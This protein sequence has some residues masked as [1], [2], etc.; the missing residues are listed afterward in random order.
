MTYLMLTVLGPFQA[1]LVGEPIAGFESNKVRALLAYLAVEAD[2]PHP[3]D[4]LAGL[5]WPE[6]PDNAARNNLRYAL[7][8]LRKAIGADRATSPL[9]C[10]S[11]QAIQ[12]NIAGDVWVDATAFTQLLA[13]PAPDLADWE[14]AIA[15]YRGE[16]LEGFFLGD[17]PA[18]EEWLLLKREQFQ[19]RMLLALHRAS[20]AHAERGDY[21]RAL[22][23]TWR[24]VELEPW[25]E[26]AHRQLM[27]LLALNNQRSAALA[28]YEACR[29]AL[30]EEL[31]VEP[32]A[33]TAQLYEQI[34]DGKLVAERP[35]ESL[36]ARQ[37][38][39]SASAAPLPLE[40]RPP[41]ASSGPT[42]AALSARRP[43][44]VGGAALLLILAAV[45]IV[46]TSGG[47]LFGQN[48]PGDARL[49][50]AERVVT[51]CEGIKPPQICAG[52]PQTGRFTPLTQDL[53]FDSIYPFLSWS[54]DG[55]HIVFSAVPAGRLSMVYVLDANDPDAPLESL[56]E[57]V[58]PAWSPDGAR[59]AFQRRGD[60]WI[61]RPDGSGAYSLT[62]QLCVIGTAWS[63]DARRIA[64]L[65]GV[66]PIPSQEPV[67][68]QSIQS[69]GGDLRTI[70]AF[71]KR[72]VGVDL[73]WSPTGDQLACHCAF[74]G[75][76][77]TWLFNVDNSGQPQ[78]RDDLPNSWFA[79]FWPQWSRSGSR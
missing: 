40:Q 38:M 11:R 17:S 18:F 3:R 1:T 6:R 70:Y 8:N 74:E 45:A 42:P 48:T 54:P 56:G 58:S 36:P 21:A 57:G 32:S 76:Q 9:L 28:Q 67:S 63:P 5:L 41:A 31:H 51:L 64:F 73:A 24:Q 50:S 29:R 4:K 46:L 61:M 43:I 35:A 68:L 59:I 62:A 19:R 52:D 44:L 60:L 34:R 20:A 14:R 77:G 72:W 30:A 27:Y 26:E 55:G 78:R 39:D 2:R 13:K 71:D 79:N 37:L 69:D 15:L 49:P 22:P 10:A 47:R 12:F 65:N 16:F 7:A 23:F 33:E 75:E 53:A 66:C 25:Q